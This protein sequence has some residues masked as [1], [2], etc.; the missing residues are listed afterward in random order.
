MT[1]P[2]QLGY[3]PIAGTAEQQRRHA[4]ADRRFE[5]EPMA[6]Q[7]LE[8]E[9]AAGSTNGVPSLQSVVAVV[10][11]LAITPALLPEALPV[12]THRMS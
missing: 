6:H 8:E 1:C 2:Q 12:Q 5:P 4:V 3:Q 11:R 10:Q 9:E 7:P